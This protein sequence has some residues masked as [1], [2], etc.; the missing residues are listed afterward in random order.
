MQLTGR[1]WEW[2]KLLLWRGAD[3]VQSTLEFRAKRICGRCW[4]GGLGCKAA[5]PAPHPPPWAITEYPELEGPHK[6]HACTGHPQESQH[7]PEMKIM[8]VGLPLKSETWQIK[9][10]GVN[11]HYKG[12]QPSS[13]PDDFLFP[14][15]FFPRA[16]SGS[17]HP[18]AK[19]FTNKT[20][21]QELNLIL[22]SVGSANKFLIDHR[23]SNCVFG[24]SPVFY[25][26]LM[27]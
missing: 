16:D 2:S 20:W 6:D 5:F 7:D 12:A 8:D 13:I 25:E 22:A 19:P 23:A 26:I 9:S 17:H 3:G 4:H 15:L 27:G 1:G 14:S 24:N 21:V 18:V 11:L 10:L